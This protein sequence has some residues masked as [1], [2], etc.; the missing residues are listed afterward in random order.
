MNKP[1]LRK[2]A[3]F[4]LDHDFSD[5]EAGFDFSRYLTGEGCGTSACAI[6]WCPVVFPNC[7]KY[8]AWESSRGDIQK[9]PTLNKYSELKYP[10]YSSMDFFNI[11]YDQHKYL[12]IP[13]VG[14]GIYDNCLSSEATAEQVGNRILE[15]I[16]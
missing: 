6:G 9:Y 2:L 15:F 5:P 11:D 14:R 1:R 13:T 12:F 16:K 10:E 7:W 3:R 8:G 4:L